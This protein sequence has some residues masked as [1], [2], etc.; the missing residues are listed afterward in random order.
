MAGTLTTPSHGA[1]ARPSSHPRPLH[2]FQPRGA[3]QALAHALGVAARR[4]EA[5]GVD[6]RSPMNRYSNSRHKSPI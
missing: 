2:P 3:P 4:S 5:S 1:K 6:Q